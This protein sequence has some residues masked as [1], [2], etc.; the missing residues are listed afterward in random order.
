[1]VSE[2]LRAG[3]VLAEEGVYVNV[4]NITS[5][6]RLYQDYQRAARN[7]AEL[8][9]GRAGRRGALAASCLPGGDASGYGHR[10]PPAYS[11]LAAVSP[12]PEPTATWL[13]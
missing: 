12:G 3:E 4:V 2:A 13:D 9:E 1:M 10:W 11:R 8:G 5:P 7:M 6:G